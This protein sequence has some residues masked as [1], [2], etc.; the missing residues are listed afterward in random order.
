MAYPNVVSM[1]QTT[2]A[3]RL[4]DAAPLL[5]RL[6][7]WLKDAEAAFLAELDEVERVKAEDYLRKASAAAQTYWEEGQG[8]PAP[9]ATNPPRADSTYV[10]HDEHAPTHVREGANQ[11]EEADADAGGGHLQKELCKLQD[12]TRLRRLEDTLRMQCN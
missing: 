11:T 8:E 2:A 10:G 5:Q 9:A 7:K 12:C 4:L 1:V 3:A 6:E